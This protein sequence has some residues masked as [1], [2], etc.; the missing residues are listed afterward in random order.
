MS[1]TESDIE[2]ISVRLANS[3]KEVEA[4]QRLRYE[5]FYEEYSAKPAPEMAAARLDFDAYD[6]YADHL[7]VVDE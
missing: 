5:V 2:S 4:A 6:E 3:A 1:Q 7:V